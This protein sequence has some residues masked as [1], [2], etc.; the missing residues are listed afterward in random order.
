VPVFLK[1]VFFDRAQLNLD[2]ATKRPYEAQI[3]SR[4]RQRVEAPFPI[5]SQPTLVSFFSSEAKKVF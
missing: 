3:S 5:V 2:L 4:D 1:H